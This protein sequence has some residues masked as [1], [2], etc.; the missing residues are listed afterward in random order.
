[1]ELCSFFPSPSG[2]MGI[3]SCSVTNLK[4]V[5]LQ[6]SC[7]NILILKSL[8][9]VQLCNLLGF[10]LELSNLFERESQFL[11]I[12]IKVKHTNLC[13]NMLQNLIR[14]G[15]VHFQGNLDKS[16][17]VMCVLWGFVCLRDTHFL[18]LTIIILSP[19][20]F[21]PLKNIAR[22]HDCL[23]SIYTECFFFSIQS[24]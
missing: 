6:C 17:I 21:F 20:Q 18:P 15:M 1:M 5:G 13:V 16:S 9:L 11:H 7:A 14:F 10:I 12:T 4:V 3:K 22:V 24:M 2:H 8:D 23:L 19:D